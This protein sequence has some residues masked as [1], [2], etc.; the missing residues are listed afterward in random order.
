MWMK[1]EQNMYHK[2]F[3][4]AKTKKEYRILINNKSHTVEQQKKK[5][6]IE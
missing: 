2:Y 1:K 6:K 3:L 5:K 4:H